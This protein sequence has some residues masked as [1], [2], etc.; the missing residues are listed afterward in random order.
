MKDYGSQYCQQFNTLKTTLPEVFRADD[1]VALFRKIGLPVSLV[2]WQCWKD[3]GNVVRVS[4]GY[5]RFKNNKPTSKELINNVYKKY[6]EKISAFKEAPK[7]SQQV[8]EAIRIC[9]EAGLTVLIPAGSL[10]SKI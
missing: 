10:Y 7:S 2:F 3:T 1:I 8:L 6:T 4:R 9:Q 5:Y